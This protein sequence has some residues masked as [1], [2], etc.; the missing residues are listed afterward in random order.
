MIRV[1][2][3]ISF[4]DRVLYFSEHLGSFGF[5]KLIKK[6]SHCSVFDFLPVKGLK[7]IKMKNLKLSLLFPI[8]LISLFFAACKKDNNSVNN[9]TPAKYTDANGTFVVL[10]TADWFTTLQ[11]S[12]GTVNLNISGNTNADKI[13]VTTYGDGLISEYPVGTTNQYFNNANIG[14]SFTQSAD[15]TLFQQSTTLQAI[16]G[17][18]TL[19][20]TLASGNLQY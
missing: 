13:T 14:I 16:K 19:K 9:K 8:L 2:S 18:D 10:S 6:I 5:I 20:V 1:I 7:T 4:R 17:T 12:S 15:K 3:Q 11:G